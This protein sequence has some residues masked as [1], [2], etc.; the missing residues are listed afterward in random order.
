MPIHLRFFTRLEGQGHENFLGVLLN[1]LDIATHRCHR[2]G[3]VVLVAQTFEDTLARVTLFG[4]SELILLQPRID[5]V[6]DRLKGRF[7]PWLRQSIARRYRVRDGLGH[8]VAGVAEFLCD[9]P[10]AH[11]IH[12]MLASN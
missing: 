10:L 12:K 2:T 11:P 3:E 8:R 9:G 4:A 5:D 1:R 7:R 6:L